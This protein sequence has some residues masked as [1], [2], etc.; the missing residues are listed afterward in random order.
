MI[1]TL[2]RAFSTQSAQHVAKK[3]P[4]DKNVTSLVKRLLETPAVAEIFNGNLSNDRI[5]ANKNMDV[6]RSFGCFPLGTYTSQEPSGEKV[7][8]PK[9]FNVGLEGMRAEL[10]FIIDKTDPLNYTEPPPSYKESLDKA[11]KAW[12]KFRSEEEIS[13]VRWPDSKVITHNGITCVA[14]EH[15]FALDVPEMIDQLWK[16]SDEELE[17]YAKTVTSFAVVTDCLYP[18]IET[19]PLRPCS[20]NMVIVKDFNIFKGT[21]YGST[22]PYRIERVIFSLMNAMEMGIEYKAPPGYVERLNYAIEN[23]LPHTTVV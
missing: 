16:M 11:K 4:W 15:R 19:L 17:I 1:S 5:S 9:Y 18:T 20:N 22:Y 10:S 8:L 14:S 6:M 2:T 13:I 3:V 12:K 23:L 7:S 21:A